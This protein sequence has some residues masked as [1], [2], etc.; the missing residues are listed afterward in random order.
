MLKKVVQVSLKSIFL[1]ISL[2]L[3]TTWDMLEK[4]LCWR[5]CGNCE[6]LMLDSDYTQ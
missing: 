2:L 4:T 3:N 1:T 5:H 6:K